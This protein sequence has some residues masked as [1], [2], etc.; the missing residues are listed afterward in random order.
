[1][2]GTPLRLTTIEGEAYLCRC[3]RILFYSDE[4]IDHLFDHCSFNNSV[5]HHFFLMEARLVG[6]P[7][8]LHDLVLVTGSAEVA[9]FLLR[10]RFLKN[11][12][13]YVVVNLEVEDLENLLRKL[14]E[15][16]M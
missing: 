2:L 13:N 15:K 7:Q 1:M 12:L 6:I 11:L 5:W 14:L 10:A 3:T 8:S 16:S 4:T 9:L